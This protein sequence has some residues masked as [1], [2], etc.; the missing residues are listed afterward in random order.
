MS[1]ASHVFIGKAE[2]RDTRIEGGFYVITLR[3]GS[4]LAVGE[5][6]GLP[7]VY[8]FRQN[9]P[10]PFNPS[11]TIKFDLPLA[12]E[13]YLVVYDLLGREVIRLVNEQMEPG[14]H[15]IVW[16]GETVEG[17]EV[18]SG[19]YIARLVTPGFTKSIKMALLK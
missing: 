11:T 4:A 13:V 19:I 16:K 12:A 9:Y 3:Q 15:Q 7:L 14:Y 8:A 18:P 17:R 10:N 5:T 2:G 1:A 6:G